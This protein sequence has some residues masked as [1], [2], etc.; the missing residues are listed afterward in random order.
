MGADEGA[1]HARVTRDHAREEGPARHDSSSSCKSGFFFFQAED[2]IRDY[3]VTGVQTCALPISAPR[4]D[5]NQ[6]HAAVVELIALDNAEIKY[7]T[8][9]NWYPGDE[10]G[11]GGIYNFVTKDWERGVLGKRGDFGGRRIIKKKKKKRSK[12]DSN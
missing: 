4:R 12:E 3:K 2:G 6:L 5:T 8:V 11:R 7:S 10:L 1:D 9:Q